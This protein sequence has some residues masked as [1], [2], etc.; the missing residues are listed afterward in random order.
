M[1]I[2]YENVPTEGEAFEGKSVLILGRGNAAFETADAIYGNTNFI[3]MVARSVAYMYWTCRDQSYSHFP[4]L[5]SSV[6]LCFY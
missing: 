4:F 6:L 5:F 3:H 1:T 2:G